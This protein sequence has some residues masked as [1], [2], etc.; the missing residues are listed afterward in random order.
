MA[1][2][3]SYETLS[4]DRAAG[5]DA[6]KKAYR[7][8]AM[9]YHPDRNPNDAGAEQN[10]KDV[11]EAYE[12]LK[13]Q[14]KR[15]AYDQFGH[16]AFDGSGAGPGGGFGFTASSFADVFDDLFGDFMGAPITPL[17]PSWDRF[18]TRLGV[19]LAIMVISPAGVPFGA[20]GRRF[21]AALRRHVWRSRRKRMRLRSAGA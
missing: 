14:E 9:Q 16:A 1:K 15:A 8:L 13:D 2:Q 5:G 19:L 17:E 18:V 21:D 20:V 4:I 3:D 6:I 7:K 11:S 10:F 12:V